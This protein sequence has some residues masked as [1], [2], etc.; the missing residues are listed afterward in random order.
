MGEPLSLWG[1]GLFTYKT[2]F[3]FIPEKLKEIERK[4]SI[5]LRNLRKSGLLNFE[6]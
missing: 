5:L 2:N 1:G 4:L 6:N 3:E